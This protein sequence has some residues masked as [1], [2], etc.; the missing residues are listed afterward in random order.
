M[1]IACI[2]GGAAGLYFAISM[3]LRDSGHEITV[4]ERNAAGN[5]FGWGM[6]FSDATIQNL[7][8]NDPETT[9]EIL[10]SFAH[11]DDIDVHF[12][13]ATITSG[14]HGFCGIARGRLLNILQRRAGELGVEVIFER[15]VE[16]IEPYLGHDLVVAADGINSRVRD[17]YAE[18]FRPSVDVR[19]NRFI[20]LGTRHK[21]DAFTFIFVHT[22][23]GW[24]WAHA[25][26]FDDDTC[27]FIVEMPEEVW[28]AAGLGEMELQAGIEWCEGLFAD[29]LDG[30]KLL[31]DAPHPRDEAWRKF[32]AIS[33]AHWS[34]D[35]VVLM[36][37][38]AH[39]AHYSIG[40]GT[41]L[42]FE[43][44]ISLA[45]LITEKGN[46]QAAFEIYEGERRLEV[47]KLQSAARNSTQWFEDVPRYAELEPIQFAYSLLTRSQRVNHENLRLRDRDWLES[48][49]SWFTGRAT[50]KEL[51]EAVPP[52]FTPYTLRGMQLANR[53]IVSP[54]AT[55]SAQD[56]EP[57]D[58]HLVHLGARAQGCAG[59]VFTEMTC[60]SAEG[61]ITP[62]CT[63]MHRQSH[64]AAWKRIVDFCHAASAAK[65]YLQ[66]GHAGPKGAT[67]LAWE[68]ADEAFDEGGWE[69]IAPSPIAWSPA[70]ATPRQMTLDDMAE[71]KEQFLRALERGA[72]A[73]FDM[74]EL[75]FGHGYLLSA[76]ITPLSNRRQDEY[77]GS[78]ENR[79]RYPP[80]ILSAVW[81]RWDKPL[82]VRISASDWVE[83]GIEAADAVTIAAMLKEAGVDIVNVSAGQTS[84]KAKP[85]YGRMFQTPFAERIRLEAGIPT[86]AAGNIF[87][88][89]HVNSIL[90]AGRADLCAL[91]RPHLANPNWTQHAAAELG[92]DG[93]QWPNPY[94][95]GKEQLERLT[96]R[97]QQMAQPI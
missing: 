75:H 57:N 11:W 37:D 74:V 41:K 33:C 60:V 40:S 51:P 21:F 55:Y 67:K 64:A 14:G 50:G 19:K 47:I 1:R 30:D 89:D 2:G 43:D 15:E 56:G 17:T 63:G 10:A 12:K 97:A 46:L 28:Q 66:L 8:D 36:G 80:E 53:I 20:W 18:K 13:D 4:I 45:D 9:R 96:E 78:L 42:A 81:A 38:A 90:A 23:H 72:I 35:N 68:G 70:N 82:S 34:F 58:F 79:M 49:E 92:Y 3:K 5:T 29:Y 31:N 48:V 26:R 24:V 6:V 54:M 88:A 93:V 84:I 76:F 59:L 7:R 73:S 95:T 27:T 65:I 16:S 22:K 87:E 71:V 86:I 77:G 94:L 52:M 32:P 85:V 62:G 39:T 91:A 61:R 69:L 25:Y 44:A 83:G